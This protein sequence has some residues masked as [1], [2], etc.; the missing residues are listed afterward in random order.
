MQEHPFVASSAVLLHDETEGRVTTTRGGQPVAHYWPN[1]G[2]LD[3]LRRG[4]D[5]AARIYF[6][7]GAS[8]VYLPYADAPVVGSE[9][10]LS[11]A[12]AEAHAIPHRISLNAVHPQGSCRLGSD[13][14]ESAADPHGEVWGERGVYVADGSLFPTS[15]GVPPQVTIMAL[16][17]AVADHVVEA[18]H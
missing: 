5:A 10:E 9:A 8:R 6:A 18:Q 14:K 3:E 2:D 7:A 16:A 13:S 11:G 17:T 12:L 1:S 15:V 4:V